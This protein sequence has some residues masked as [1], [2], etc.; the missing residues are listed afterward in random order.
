MRGLRFLQRRQVFFGPVSPF[1]EELFSQAPTVKTKIGCVEK[2]QSFCKGISGQP[3]KGGILQ[4]S[5]IG[6]RNAGMRGRFFQ[7]AVLVDTG[8]SEAFTHRRG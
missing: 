4:G 1:L 8:N 5:E 7:S 2:H 6:E 3:I